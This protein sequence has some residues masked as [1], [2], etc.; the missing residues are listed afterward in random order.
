MVSF[1]HQVKF[2]FYVG[3]HLT[4][5]CRSSPCTFNLVSKTSPKW[6][7]PYQFLL[8]AENITK[9]QLLSLHGINLCMHVILQGHSCL[10][11]WWLDIASSLPNLDNLISPDEVYYP[12]L[13]FWSHLLDHW[14]GIIFFY[15][16]PLTWSS[17]SQMSLIRWFW[18]VYQSQWFASHWPPSFSWF[19]CHLGWMR[20]TQ[21]L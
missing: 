11:F 3:V 7:Q 2:Q 17:S 20:F 5:G 10:S 13:R 6:K 18:G 12:D 16:I 8:S 15:N 14:Y 1:R 21:F 9:Q 19:I 4:S